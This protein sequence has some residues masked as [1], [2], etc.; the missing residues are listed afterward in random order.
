MS[1]Y[2]EYLDVKSKL[3]SKELDFKSAVNEWFAEHNDV[4]LMKPVDVEASLTMDHITITANEKFKD[5]LHDFEDTFTLKN[6]RI[7]HTEIIVPDDYE[8][9]NVWKFHFREQ[10]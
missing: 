10:K 6:I 9:K 7:H 8:K 4:M 5:Y 2:S 3:L 1:L